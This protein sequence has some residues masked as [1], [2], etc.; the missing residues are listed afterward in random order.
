[1]IKLLSLIVPFFACLLALP[2]LAN[3]STPISTIALTQHWVG[4]VS[5]ALFVLAY[6]L[7][8]LEDK[9]H[10]KKSKP[11]L[12]VAGTIWAVIAF[13]YH[14]NG[15]S[16]QIA[17]AI[18]EY[19]LEYAQLFFF[20]LVAMTYINSMMERDVFNALRH[21]LTNKG[22]TFRSLFWITGILAFFISPIADNL[23]TAL[24]LC[25]VIMAVASDKPHFI[26]P[27]SINIVVAA[28]AGGAFSPFGDI[29]TLMVW[30]KGVV[31]FT[32]FGILFLPSVVNY[33][34]PAFI[35]QFALPRG[36]PQ[37]ARSGHISVQQGGLQIVALFL[38]TIITAVS[39]H[40]WLGIPPVYGMLLGLAY[41]K[42][43][44]FWLKKRNPKW[45]HGSENPPGSNDD[46]YDFDVFAQIAHAEWDTLFFFYGV[47][48]SV[49]GLG[50]V[51]Y[52]ELV[53]VFMYEDMGT[54]QAN[55][56]VGVLSAFID[57]I[58]VMFS[59]L[60]MEPVMSQSQWLLVTLT[61][62]VG[63]SMLS[64]GS[65]AGVAL[66]GQ[67]RGI[68]TFTAHLKWT[69][70]I[71]LGYVASVLLHMWMHDITF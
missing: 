26:V 34:I 12:L 33:L 49:G 37:P 60:T 58:P 64:I 66:M 65:A 52:L 15:Q 31:P 3:S 23:T 47:I 35:L 44:G 11:V 55:I 36:R 63:G 56:L 19:F 9:I 2:A 62:G 59:V 28:N 45:S 29:T 13:Y 22:F 20:L 40:H 67:T 46:P 42:L 27:S 6:I 51:G 53:S 38:L 24:I 61:A 69:P 16:E 14:N 70:V 8:A 41:L 48:M 68:Y 71:A 54:T 43:F 17:P 10:L 21:W 30:Q 4:Y 7:V 39:F 18:N 50:F 25:A 5:L 32:E 57:N 1:M